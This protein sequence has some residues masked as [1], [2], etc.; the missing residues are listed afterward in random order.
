MTDPV[1][2]LAR[3]CS[4]AVLAEPQLLRSLRLGLVPEADAGAEADLWWSPLVE[5]RTT[6][7]VVLT[8]AAAEELRTELRKLRRAG[9]PRP[10]TAWGI[11]QAHHWGT[12]PAV[13][14]EEE[15][16]WLSVSL[17]EPGQAIEARLRTALAALVNE[18]RTGLG[19]W[20]G[21][22]LPR[23]PEVARQ[24]P[25]AWYLEQEAHAQL[26]HLAALGTVPPA[27]VDL[28]VLA[29]M[30][31]RMPP[32]PLGV[33]RSGDRLYLGDVGPDGHAIE[34]PATDPRVVEVVRLEAAEQ[35][36]GTS[37]EPRPSVEVH[38]GALKR[39]DVG[40][41]PVTLRSAY[42]NAYDLPPMEGLDRA[43]VLDA[44][45]S[46]T[47]R[48][49]GRNQ[50]GVVVGDG[51]VATTS[52]ANGVEGLEVMTPVGEEPYATVV[53]RRHESAVLLRVD[54][55][56]PASTLPVRRLRRLPERGRR[57]YGVTEEP[58]PGYSYATLAGLVRD[59]AFVDVP[60]SPILLQA[61]REGGRLTE[62]E[63]AIGGPVI[64]DGEV[65]GLV[66]GLVP[67]ADIG[68]DGDLAYGDWSDLWAVLHPEAARATPEQW[69][70]AL[71][72]LVQALCLE[73]HTEFRYFG[74]V[75][76]RDDQLTEEQL[77]SLRG[78]AEAV[79]D[80]AVTDLLTAREVLADPVG[81]ADEAREVADLDLDPVLTA[82]VGHDPRSAESPLTGSV[83]DVLLAPL[84]EARPR[85]VLEPREEAFRSQIEAVLAPAW[86][87][88]RDNLA[89]LR[90]PG[91]SPNQDLGAFLEALLGAYS[92][93]LA[94]VA[95][96]HGSRAYQMGFGVPADAL[97]ILPV[98]QFFDLGVSELGGSEVEA[99]AQ[100][101]NE[102]HL[103]ADR[104]E[105]L[106][107]VFDWARTDLVDAVATL[108]VA[109]SPPEP[110]SARPAGLRDPGERGA[111]TSPSR[112]RRTDV[113]RVVAVHGLGQQLLGRNEV[114]ARWL[115]A[116]Q[117]ALA[118]AGAEPLA[119]GELTVPFY[120]DLFRTP[121]AFAEQD[122]GNDPI[123]DEELVALW[124][125]ATT[126]EDTPEPDASETR[127]PGV[128]QRA[129]RA[130]TSSK[131]FGG[132]SERALETFL[133]QIASYLND[134]AIRRAAQNRVADAVGSETRIV[135]AHS[136]GSIVAYETL[137]AYPEWEIQLFVTLGSP[138]GLR[139]I[140]E[141]LN[142]LPQNGIGSWPGS[143]KRWTNIA[144]RG[145]I[146]ALE[147]RLGTRF[148]GP[149]RDILIDNGVQADSLNSY[150]T[151]A[152]T[153]RAIA[154]GL[155]SDDG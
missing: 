66:T 57:W 45:V 75:R 139:P 116:L 112:R 83:V 143:I 81:F 151:A 39:V 16:A 136:L 155:T 64:V 131:V 19:Q 15:I 99:F 82:L 69:L 149:V 58:I 98:R 125:T 148:A 49:S 30:A 117:D 2:E 56:L 92:R 87:S 24:Q 50:L 37:G 88:Y 107:A 25:S 122:A 28:G 17:D 90:T 67:G 111:A 12:S 51:L 129:L 59:P 65:A 3:W 10:A 7:G 78:L 8:A 133:G 118:R 33:L 76:L 142:P 145:D 103:Y 27:E 32:T 9:D 85:R 77:G 96:R 135:L 95:D 1:R 70:Q 130:L 114:R 119:D 147:K 14:L 106:V 40:W 137:C 53:L 101:Q 35:Y 6:R 42:G 36:Q 20:A 22:A 47:H 128:V 23:L 61:R 121:S 89:D 54:G 104:F 11:V 141:R 73:L 94:D 113:A 72:D 48:R 154:A 13:K 91:F 109:V 105:T 127:G 84:R 68:G 41:G 44:L 21:R 123:V 29:R 34:V 152:E 52:P 38:A 140:F 150:L 46:V 26:P 124:R 71:A 134:P 80:Q 79:V 18:D 153:G 97:E 126:E 146:V 31:G 138:L 63:S 43:K 4:L 5:S 110:E 144:D 74:G 62:P 60:G 55:R 132:L 93:I 102:R 100:R 115:P 108:H 120:G 86:R